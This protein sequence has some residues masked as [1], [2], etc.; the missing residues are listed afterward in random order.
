MEKNVKTFLPG[1]MESFAPCSLLPLLQS[2]LKYMGIAN[3]LV[4]SV[5]WELMSGSHVTCHA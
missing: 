3:F 5:K 2:L 4:L 1:I